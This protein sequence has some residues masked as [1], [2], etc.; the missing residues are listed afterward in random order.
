[1]T[2]TKKLW[3]I[4]IVP[5]DRKRLVRQILTILFFST[6]IGLGGLLGTY[7]AVKQG[8]PDVAEIEKLT[9]S[10]TTAILADDGRIV[11]EIGPEK[12]ILVA[13]DKIPEVLKQAIPPLLQT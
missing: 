7:I 11:K 8:L 13:Y 10:L 2:P 9:P 6:A 3:K 5:T 12:R 4:R 1:M